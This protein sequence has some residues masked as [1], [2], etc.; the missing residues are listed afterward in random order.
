MAWYDQVHSTQKFRLGTKKKAVDGRE[1]IYLKGVA[2]VTQGAWVTYD[3]LGVTTNLATDSN[4]G[5]VAIAMAAVDSTSEY[6]WW[7]IYGHFIC[8]AISGGDAAADARVFASATDFLPDDVEA[9]DMQVLNAVFRSQEG[10]ANT[11]LGLSATAGLA[12][13]QVNYPWFGLAVDASA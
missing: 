8:G 13:A 2:N 9:D 12:T 3:E 5:P 11:T 1:F 10:E 7:G 4:P 6:G